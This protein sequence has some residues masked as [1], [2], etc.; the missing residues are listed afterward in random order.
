[1]KHVL[2][3]VAAVMALALCL[4]LAA[5]GGGQP[6]GS[7]T[8][9]GSKKTTTT[10]AADAAENGDS[11]DT[12][13]TAG[14]ETTT[15]TPA[16]EDKPTPTVHTKNVQGGIVHTTEAPTTTKDKSAG[17]A[18]KILAVGNSFSVD[19]M[20]KHL[21]SI[22]ES[23]GYT[24]ITLGNLYIG[25]CSLD[26]HYTNLRDNLKAYTY[27]LNT[28]GDWTATDAT[29]ASA[30][31]STA[32]WDVVTIQQVSSDSGRPATYTNLEAVVAMIRKSEPQAKILWHMTWAYQQDSTHNAFPRYDKDQMTMYNAIVQTVQEQVLPLTAIHGVIP[33][34]TAIQNLRTSALGDTL[35]SDGHHLLDSYGDYTAALTWFCTITGEKPQAV[36]Y[37]PA[38]VADQWDA[39]AASVENAV[40]T[41]YAVT[42]L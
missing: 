13:T 16:K 28:D 15:T 5:C 25:G 36:S 37:R 2:R 38:A 42:Q 27:Y 17:K 30:A 18:I 39:I 23:A 31:F 35:T 11:A 9:P 29:A 33:A 4:G 34:G 32:K 12:T 14:E 26:T 24:D 8:T 1:M 22:L 7:D 41:P 21:F 19:A 10:T 6:D 3:V 40:K 20:K